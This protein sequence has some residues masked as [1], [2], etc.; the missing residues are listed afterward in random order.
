MRILMSVFACG[1]NRG[2]EQAVS[3][4]LEAT[5]FGRQVVALTQTGRR[6][7]I[8]AEAAAGRLP[9]WLDRLRRKG[10]ALGWGQLSPH[11]AHPLWQIL[12]CGHARRQ[13]AD[14]QV[15]LIPHATFG[16]IRHPTPGRA[17]G[18]LQVRHL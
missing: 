15:D 4:A 13:L 2:S 5:R 8:E 12:A 9:A 17:T 7:E 11:L 16:G 6:A 10:M 1:P 3:W 14:W 18:R